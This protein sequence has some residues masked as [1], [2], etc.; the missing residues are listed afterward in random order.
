[1]IDYSSNSHGTWCLGPWSR[2]GRSCAGGCWA[3]RPWGP[4][5]RSGGCHTWSAPAAACSSDW[6]SL[7]WKWVSS[8]I[9]MRQICV[10]P[11]FLCIIYCLYVSPSWQ[12][13]LR[14][15]T[16]LHL[17][18]LM[19]SYSVSMKIQSMKPRI[20][21]ANKEETSKEAGWWY[22]DIFSYLERITADNIFPIKPRREMP[23]IY[24]SQNF[25]WALIYFCTLMNYLL[26]RL[27]GPRTQTLHH[28]KFRSSLRVVCRLCLLRILIN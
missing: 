17:Y 1:M 25:W 6:T 8:W 13:Y 2:G 11:I 15:K 24:K 4:R 10:Y 16:Y 18:T 27:R 12:G 14:H 21:K 7:A 26:N 3:P 20:V 9:T 28:S 19:R 5:S 23:G 22:K